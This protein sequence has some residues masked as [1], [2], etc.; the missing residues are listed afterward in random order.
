M[1]NLK[2]TDKTSENAEKELRISD[3][4]GRLLQKAE[5][6]YGKDEDVTY[7]VEMVGDEPWIIKHTYIPW[8]RDDVIQLVRVNDL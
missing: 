7:K 2:N 4:I 1:E 6:I 3:V 5:L 8:E